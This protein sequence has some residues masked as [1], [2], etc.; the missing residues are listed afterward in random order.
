MVLDVMVESQRRDAGFGL[1]TITHAF[2]SEQFS[3]S[4]HHCWRLFLGPLINN[5]SFFFFGV[6]GVAVGVKRLPPILHGNCREISSQ[7]QNTRFN[8]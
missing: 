7:T 8:I 6:G 3:H 5:K 4:K 1:S 2:T